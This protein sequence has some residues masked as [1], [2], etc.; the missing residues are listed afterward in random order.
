MVAVKRTAVKGLDE[1]GDSFRSIARAVSPQGKLADMMLAGGEVGVTAVKLHILKQRLFKTGA[2]LESVK[3]V[4]INQFRVDIIV[5]RVYA[6]AH[7]YG[8][9][10]IVPVTAKSRRF[11][12]A[13][14]F[15]TNDDKWRAMA[16]S[17]KTSFVVE[18]KARPYVRP[19]L[20]QERFSIIAAIQ[21]ELL[22]V[23]KRAV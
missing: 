5:D 1:L 22:N 17:K 21:S 14:Y 23:I 10:I 18:I 8:A 4:K 20:K 13:M 7:E 6:A 15:Q 11:F 3:A 19:A 9:T 12:W 16:L 2:L